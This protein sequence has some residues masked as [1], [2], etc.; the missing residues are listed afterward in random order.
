MNALSPDDAERL[1]QAFLRCR[2][3]DGSLAER[4]EA[5]AAAGREIFPAYSDAVDR[6]VERIHDN[7]GG[8]N[9]PRPGEPMPAF[10]LPDETGRLVSLPSLLADGPL[11]V[12]FFRGHWCP[13]CRLSVRAAIEATDRIKSAGGRVVGIMPETQTFTARFKADCGVPFPLLTD[14]DNG[15]ALSLN[16]AIWLG[17]D[18]QQLLA[19]HD[20]AR[21]HGN[22]GWVLPIPATFVVG[23]DGTVKARFVDPD[24]RRRMAIDD[25]IAALRIAR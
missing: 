23:G 16:L 1:R 5:Y 18:I 14:L 13:Y 12:M 20:M 3:M 4:L 22:D 8:E 17:P 24:F 9:A 10:V 6:L 15:Y 25:M 2:D 21:F 11:V 7:G 19:Y